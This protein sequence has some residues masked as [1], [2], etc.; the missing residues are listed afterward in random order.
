MG[1]ELTTLVVIGTTI[2]PRRA[3]P[4]QERK[5]VKYHKENTTSNE[6]AVCLLVTASM[7]S[8]H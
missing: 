1:L 7:G 6:F 2:R 8:I 3:R 5:K 4:S